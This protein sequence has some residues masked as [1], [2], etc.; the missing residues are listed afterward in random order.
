MIVV[1]GATGQLGRLVIDELLKRTEAENIVAAVRRPAKGN[2]FAERGIQV[3]EADYSRPE[4][5]AAAFQGASRLLLIFGQRPG[6]ARRTT[7]GRHRCG[8]SNR[9]HFR[10]VHESSTLRH[11]PS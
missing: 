4:T 5:L 6:Q 2:D 3:R 1:T 9:Y 11:F 7:Q 10:R 8:E